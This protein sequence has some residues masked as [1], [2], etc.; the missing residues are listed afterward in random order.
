MTVLKGAG[1]EPVREKTGE[2]TL[3]NC[4]FDALA[5]E[6]KELVC[7]MNLALV[8]GMVEG[9][10]ARGVSARLDPKPGRS[11]VALRLAA[12]G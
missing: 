11:C 10:G 3:R 4:P 8:Q 12:E 7:G 2:I 1:F 5:R 6:S 9:L